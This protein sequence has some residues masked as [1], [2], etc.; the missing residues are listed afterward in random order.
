M[1]VHIYTALKPC[2]SDKPS[3]RLSSLIP[4]HRTLMS[5]SDRLRSRSGIKLVKKR[6]KYRSLTGLVSHAV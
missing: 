2:D 4:N 6:L 5:V 1:F 3:T